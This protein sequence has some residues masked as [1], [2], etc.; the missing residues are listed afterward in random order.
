[1][2]SVERAIVLLSGGVDSAVC[3]WLARE[4]G[5][6][7]YTISYNYH[8]RHRREISASRELSKAAGTVEHKLIDLPFLKEFEDTLLEVENPLYKQRDIIPR[9]YIPSRNLVFYSIAA[10]WAEVISA[11]HIIGGHHK[12]DL[13]SFPDA[14][15]DFFDLV[16]EA[17]ALG[18]KASK[19]MKIEII[20]PLHEYEKSMIIS[21]AIR[22]KVPLELTWSCHRRNDIACGKCTACVSRLQSFRAVGMEDPI[23]YLPMM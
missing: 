19:M 11:S 17:I 10:S 15:A 9:A 2:T 7:T 13:Q 20:A 22:L 4:R 1:M 3:L 23:E 16:N 18:S 12:G 8:G 21:E 5:F 14:T 6:D